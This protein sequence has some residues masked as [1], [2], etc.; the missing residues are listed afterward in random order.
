MVKYCTKCGTQIIEGA[1]FCSFCGA[2]TNQVIDTSNQTNQS[3]TPVQQQTN[4]PSAQQ[5]TMPPPVQQF[6]QTASSGIWYQNQYK[7]RKK[8]LTIWNKY[9][10][11]DGNGKILGFTK[12]KMFKLKEDIRIYTDENIQQ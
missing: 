11:E 1:A 3:H 2:K 7:M 9:W 12:Q 5:T 4:T 8:V 10:I 6:V